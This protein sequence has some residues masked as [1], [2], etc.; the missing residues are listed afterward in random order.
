MPKK[1]KDVPTEHA[2]DEEETEID[3]GHGERV[4]A[5]A[6][7]SNEA[8]LEE[9]VRQV[10]QQALIV[11]QGDKEDGLGRLPSVGSSSMS[12]SSGSRVEPTKERSSVTVS[13][14]ADNRSSTRALDPCIVLKKLPTY[15]GGH[16]EDFFAW[17]DEM[18]AIRGFHRLSDDELARY[19]PWALEGAARQWLA[20]QPDEVQQSGQSTL[21][22]LAETY[23]HLTTTR[24]DERIW[25][26][27]QGKDESGCDF[28]FCLRREAN[29]LPGTFSAGQLEGRWRAG[30]RPD[31]SHFVLQHADKPFEKQLR[32]LHIYER[33]ITHR[34]VHTVAT[35][36]P[37]E[38]KIGRAT[39]GDS[40]AL[41][42][43]RG[44]QRRRNCGPG[45][46]ECS[47]E[48]HIRARCPRQQGATLTLTKPTATV[49]AP[50]SDP[51][52]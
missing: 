43:A 1:G 52:N 11:L 50:K 20:L 28:W 3:E 29:Q 16:N 34:K 32:R 38:G 27:R 12:G 23:G 41:D 21:A 49:P 37:A 39:T 22:V 26:A 48:G 40:R 30:L 14:Q 5:L 25:S 35:V 47:Q 6:Q 45:C 8:V 18:D 4:P 24:L 36:Q 31:L 17:F 46:W 10:V 33:E 2:S 51:S 15:K 7:G 13:G 19:T 9:L 42:E 44:D